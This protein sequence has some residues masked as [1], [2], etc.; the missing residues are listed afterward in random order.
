MSSEIFPVSSYWTPQTGSPKQLSFSQDETTLK[1][2]LGSPGVVLSWLK[3]SFM[4][5]EK[6]FHF[7]RRCI[8]GEYFNF[9]RGTCKVRAFQGSEQYMNLAMNHVCP[10]PKL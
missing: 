8:Q 7:F 6:C 9:S 3:V 10:I 1:K 4:C 5:W 2:E